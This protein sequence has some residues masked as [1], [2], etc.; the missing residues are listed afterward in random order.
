MRMFRINGARKKLGENRVLRGLDLEVRKG[1]IIALPPRH[2][3][4]G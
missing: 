3:I 2:I 4:S 1:E